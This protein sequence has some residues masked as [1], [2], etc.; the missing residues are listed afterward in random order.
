[1][2]SASSIQPNPR[3]AAVRTGVRALGVI[4]VGE[5]WHGS[6]CTGLARGF[7]DLGHL[8]EQIG[9]DRFFPG[10]DRSRI[11]RGAVR[12][13]WPFCRVQFNRRILDAVRGRQPD[14]VVVCKGAHVTPATLAE[15]RRRGVWLCNFWPDV[16]MAGHSGVDERIFG[17]FNHVFTTK[18]FGVVDMEARLGL[19]DASFVPVGFDPRVHRPVHPRAAAPAAPVSFAGSWSPGKERWL[20]PL[21][22]AIGPERLSV[23]GDRWRR[24]RSAVVRRVIRGGPVYGDFYAEL[25]AASRI[26]LGL[27][28][29]RVAGA[30]SGDL[31]TART[32]E[33]PACG[34]F[35]LHQRTAELADMFDEDREVACFGSPEELVEKVEYYLDHEAERQ[36]IA[37]AGHRRCLRDHA[38]SQQAR[39]IVEKFLAERARPEQPA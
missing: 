2:T 13:L 5:S 1:M 6:G 20:A 11:A 34:G 26:N 36:G 28:S 15:V 4:L 10:T 23:R 32:V 24:A 27:L 37:R 38:A 3:P 16:S 19:T 17:Y 21:A 8:V 29:E 35:L 30:S 33:I 14:V 7:R 25:I 12:A 18:S 31:V 22:A 39:V 9:A